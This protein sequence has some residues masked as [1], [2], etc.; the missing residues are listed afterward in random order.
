MVLCFVNLS[1]PTIS[2]FYESGLGLQI[3]DMNSN[4][5]GMG[6]L[7][8]KLW[9]AADFVNHDPQNEDIFLGE[10]GNLILNTVQC[11]DVFS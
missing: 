6:D 8:I 9:Q 7:N 11:L 5:S 2:L 3:F 4:W 1:K 10:F